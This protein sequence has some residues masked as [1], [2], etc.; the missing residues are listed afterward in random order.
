[1]YMKRKL[2]KHWPPI[3]IL[4]LVSLAGIVYL[5]FYY[6]P[7]QELLQATSSNDFLITATKYISG[8]DGKAVG[9]KADSISQVVGVMIDNHPD[10][11]PES[12]VSKA[13]IVYEA[14]VEG[15]L[16]RYLAIFDSKQ[17]VAEVG[18]VRSARAYFLDWLQEYGNGLYMHSGGSPDALS[19]IKQKNIFDAN[20]FFR[21]Q[22]YWRSQDRQAPHNLYTSSS[23]WVRIVSKYGSTSSLFTADKGW[24]YAR[25]VGKTIGVSSTIKIPFSDDYMVAWVYD[26]KKL[27][28][29][30]AINGEKE[31]L[32]LVK[33]KQASDNITRQAYNKNFI[34][35]P[36]FEINTDINGIPNNWHGTN[37]TTTTEDSQNGLVSVRTKS[38]LTFTKKTQLWQEINYLWAKNTNLLFTGWVKIIDPIET[39]YSAG[40]SLQAHYLN[41]QSSNFVTLLD[42]NNQEWQLISISIQLN[43]LTKKITIKPFLNQDGIIYFDNF[44]LRLTP[45]IIPNLLY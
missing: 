27:N 21:G 11:R 31:P 22:Y 36:S 12:A 35:N 42:P 3:I 44:S 10:S 37:I 7:S 18:P 15:G 23:N 29:A 43:Q 33:L 4:A 30:R 8:L 16:T 2:S 9:K 6:Y 45:E 41:N 13:K 20:E 34:K 14:S 38:D 39:E 40:I 26:A 32:F 1:M 19:V 17:A 28:Y 24:K 5:F 25:I